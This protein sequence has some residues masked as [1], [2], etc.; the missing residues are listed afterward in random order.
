MKQIHQKFKF[1]NLSFKY[2]SLPR[3]AYEYLIPI[4]ILSLLLIETRH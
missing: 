4:E 3:N 2:L 1:V